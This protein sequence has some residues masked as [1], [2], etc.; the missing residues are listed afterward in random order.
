LL[1]RELIDQIRQIERAT[2]RTDVLSG[3]VAKLEGSLA[4]FGA[5]FT[6]C[7][8]RDD[9]A[10]AVR[11]AHTLKGTCRQLGAV[12]LGDLFDEVER[13]AKAGDYAGAKRAFE[14]GAS[15]VAQSLHALKHA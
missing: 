9:T 6:D 5:A 2:G 3:F 4:G 13:V 12:A 7:V 1:D 8:A 10:G 15:V 14:H 11:A